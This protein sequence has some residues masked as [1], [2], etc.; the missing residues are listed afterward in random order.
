M[1]LYPHTTKKHYVLS[2]RNTQ[3]HFVTLSHNTVS[4]TFHNYLVAATASPNYWLLSH[5]I[6]LKHTHNIFNAMCYTLYYKFT[7]P[8]IIYFTVDVNRVIT[9]YMANAIA[10]FFFTYL[11]NCG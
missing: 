3:L 9:G 1:I 4:V 2:H 6:S 7:T 11:G 8:K 10:M 5:V